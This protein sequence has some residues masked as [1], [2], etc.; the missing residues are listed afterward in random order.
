MKSTSRADPAAPVAAAPNRR[1]LLVTTLWAILL[2]GLVLL[3]YQPLWNAGF[4]WDDNDYVTG[5]EHLRSVA[6]LLRIWLEPG[7]VPQYYPLVH[8]SY[9]LE[10]RLWELR[11]LGYHVSNVLLHLATALLAWRLLLRLAVPGAGLAAAIFAL[12]PVHVESVAWITERKNLLSAVFYLGAALSY[13]RFAPA[14]GDA[15]GKPARLRFWYALALL[16]FVAA[17]LSKTVTASLPAAILL[18]TWW[19]Q[20][21]LP[22]ARWK[23]LAPFFLLGIIAGLHTIYLEKVRVGA[24]GPDWDLSFIERCLIAGRASWFYLGKLAWPEPLAFF[25]PKWEID[26]ASAGQYLYPTA[27]LLLLA[28]LWRLRRRIGRGPLT[29]ALFFGGTLVPALGFFD[30][31][32]MRFSWVADHFQ[33]LASLG[34]IT[35]A[36]AAA[37]TL[38][39]KLPPPNTMAGALAALLMLLFL[40]FLSHRQAGAYRDEETLWQR[41]IAANPKAF[42]AYHNLGTLRA[43]QGRHEEALALWQQA[44]SIHE[45][46]EAFRNIGQIHEMRGD[47]SAAISAYEDSIRLQPDYVK[48]HTRIGG[49]HL[50][51]QEWKKAEKAYRKGL[52]YSPGQVE[53]LMGLGV[54]LATRAEHREAED[55]YQK[56]LVTD[57]NHVEAHHQ[58]GILLAHQSKPAEAEQHFREAVRHAPGHA[59][60]HANLAALLWQREKRDES[61]QHYRRALEAAP[62]DFN[63]RM[64]LCQ[65]LI[66]QELFRE[67]AQQLRTATSLQPAIPL[68]WYQLGMS[69][70][71]TDRESEAITA[72]EQALT[73][74]PDYEDARNLL[75]QIQARP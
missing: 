8:T 12:H 23:P 73:L 42:A 50:Q 35:L 5:N 13:F 55:C 2:P 11:P 30:F 15:P 72:L 68:A 20:G 54:V 19:K 36:A 33:Y 37:T 18:M 4:I 52:R 53:C 38:W 16:L 41:T 49:C 74:Q 17:L 56:V 60:A 3:A 51:Q 24:S 75:E 45:T 58:L 28:L 64:H 48:S 71:K 67:A 34:P 6:G 66:A 44:Q 63:L 65:A 57:P 21:C 59:R 70:E 40:A 22:A 46:A 39:R 62:A 26:A 27:A 9:W 25:Y 47:L 29:A 7:A 1:S 10:H 43:S 14:Q 61:T 32:P 31:Y 69:L